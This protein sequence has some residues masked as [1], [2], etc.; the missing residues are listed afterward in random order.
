[1]VPGSAGPSIWQV[2]RRD[3]VLS[4]GILVPVG[5]SITRRMERAPVGSALQALVP[6][7]SSLVNSVAVEYCTR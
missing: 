6:F 2:K 5:S 3:T 7:Q 4:F 1:M